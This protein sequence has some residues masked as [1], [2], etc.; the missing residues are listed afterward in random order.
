MTASMTGFARSRGTHGGDSWTWE[1]KSVNARGLDV[2]IRLPS[3]NEEVEAAVR[4]AIAKRFRR[5][6]INVNLT[7]QRPEGD[8]PLQVDREHLDRLLAVV[9][10]MGRE[11][12]DIEALMTVR[13]VVVAAVAKLDEADEAA[14]RKAYTATFA[15]ALE[16]LADARRD[17]GE[18]LAALLE[19]RLSEIETCIADAEK[20][21]AARPEAARARLEAQVAELL[22]CAPAAPADRLAQELA[23]LAVKADVREE[24]DRLTAH[25]AQARDLLAEKEAVGRRFDFL[26]QEFNREANTLCAKSG[27]VSLTRIGLALKANID[28]LREQVQNV[29]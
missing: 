15:D 19:A 29:E 20:T 1:A 28:Q 24:I 25:V 18:R 2:R 4:N 6:S 9:R 5:G 14:R 13:G 23:L 8:A 12:P 17:E 3:G 22:D 7:V 27:D 11:S 10:D 26:C 16:R 21:A